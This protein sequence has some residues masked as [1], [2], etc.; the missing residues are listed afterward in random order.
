MD[1]SLDAIIN[2]I[3]RSP[4]KIAAIV[5]GFFVLRELANLFKMMVIHPRISPLKDLPGPTEGDSFLFG[6]MLAFISKDPNPVLDQWYE[7]YGPI[8]QFRSVFRVRWFLIS[9]VLPK[10]IPHPLSR[11]VSFTSGTP[12]PSHTL[13]TMHTSFQSHLWRVK[14]S[15]I[16]SAPVGPTWFL[17]RVSDTPQRQVYLRQKVA[18]QSRHALSALTKRCQVMPTVGSASS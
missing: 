10:L 2:A 3:P 9:L 11:V 6:H 14:G 12:K 1:V 15:K 16:F 7:K 5:A 17:H 13:S 4:W 8:V 18:E